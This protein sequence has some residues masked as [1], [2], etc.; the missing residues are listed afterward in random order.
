MA[1]STGTT[2]N[3][4][5][6]LLRRVSKCQDMAGRTKTRISGDGKVNIRKYRVRVHILG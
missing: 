5:A 4:T 6:V 1:L 2:Q 3:Q